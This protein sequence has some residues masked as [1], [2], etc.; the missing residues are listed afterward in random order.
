M[1][2]LDLLPV[3]EPRFWSKVTGG[4]YLECWPWVAP[5]TK[6]YGAFTVT[7]SGR[8]WSEGAHRTAYRLLIGEIPPG[9]DLDHLCRN[10]ACVNPWHLEPVTRWVNWD[11]G[12]KHLM[13]GIRNREKTH[14]KRGHEFTEENIYRVPNGRSCWTCR[15][16]RD[17]RRV[18]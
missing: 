1:I 13:G 9:L 16:E 7:R 11:R 15:R 18:R 14:C 5:G 12:A 17:R 6:G 10:H 2:P 3:A 4:D 8:C